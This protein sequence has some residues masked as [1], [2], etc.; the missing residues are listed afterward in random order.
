M[1]L[2]IIN[3]KIS[4]NRKLLSISKLP[5]L[6]HQPLPFLRKNKPSLIFWRINRTSISIP[7]VKWGILSYD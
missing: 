7:F 1:F 5:L 2:G 4:N 6:F 3:T